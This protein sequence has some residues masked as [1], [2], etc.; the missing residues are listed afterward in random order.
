MEADLAT[1]EGV[2]R[3]LAATAGREIDLSLANAGRGLGKAFID[4]HFGGVRRVIDTNI[5]GTVYLAR[6]V[7]RRMVARGEGRILFTGSI[8]GF[9]PRTFQADYNGTKAFIDSFAIAL[10]PVLQRA[11][12]DMCPRRRPDVAA[13]CWCPPC[14]SPAG[15]LATDGYVRSEPIRIRSP[16]RSPGR[17]MSKARSRYGQSNRL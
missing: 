17:S 5:T 14:H 4:Q 8:A 3:L 1:T 16:M 11:R 7:A 12:S 13:A 6:K 2:D 9:M 15:H 10:R